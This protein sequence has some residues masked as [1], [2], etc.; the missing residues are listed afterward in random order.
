LRKISGR[1]LA[2][3]LKADAGGPYTATEGAK[4]ALDASKSSPAG[5]ITSYAWD[6]DAGGE[7]NDATGAAK[8]NPALMADGASLVRRRLSRNRPGDQPTHADEPI[9]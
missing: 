2:S 3:P 9:H 1:I 5:D 8:L 7:Y 6:L 4:V